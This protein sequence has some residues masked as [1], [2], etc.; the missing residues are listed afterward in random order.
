MT[1]I[2]TPVGQHGGS[3][4]FASGVL[5]GAAVSVILA[6]ALGLAAFGAGLVEWAQQAVAPAPNVS[7]WT[8]YGERH[9][10]APAP[11][12]SQWTDYGERQLAPPAHWTDYGERK[13]NQ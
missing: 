3:H 10:V 1:A 12:V 7:Q 8:D 11:N 9:L 4:P 5:A 2:N 6:A 13:L